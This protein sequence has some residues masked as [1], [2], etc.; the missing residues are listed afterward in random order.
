MKGKT[1][2]VVAVFSI[3]FGIAW[4]SAEEPAGDPVFFI[5][6]IGSHGLYPELDYRRFT[7]VLTA[8]GRSAFIQDIRLDQDFSW[9]TA[10]RLDDSSGAIGGIRRDQNFSLI[11]NADLLWLTPLGSA[12]L[13]AGIGADFD[14]RQSIVEMNDYNAFT[15]HEKEET[16]TAPYALRSMLLWASRGDTLAQGYRLKY[17]LGVSPAV[18]TWLTDG[19][20]D[21]VLEYVNDTL[22]DADQY[23]H[24]A[25]ISG[26]WNRQLGNLLVTG[27]LSYTFGY[28]SRSNKYLS[29]DTT[30]DGYRETV[31]SYQDWSARSGTG[32]P[33]EE[34]TSFNQNDEEY[35][36]RIDLNTLIRITLSDSLHLQLS[37]SY[38]PLDISSRISYTRIE[39]DSIPD[40]MSWEGVNRSQ[41]WGNFMI[42]G[43]LASQVDSEKEGMRL[44]LYYNRT[45]KTVLLDGAQAAGQRL[46]HRDNPGRY[47]EVDLGRDPVRG[48]IMSAVDYPSLTVVHDLQL[49]SGRF[50]QFDNQIRI[51]TG[52][53]LNGVL[54]QEHYRAYNLN[55]RT[56]WEEVAAS[57]GLG[58]LLLPQVGVS[59][60]LGERW[61]WI[62]DIGAFRIPGDYTQTHNTAPQDLSVGRVTEDGTLDLLQRGGIAFALRMRFVLLP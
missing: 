10:Q 38:T 24:Q 3:L 5:S 56:V 57:N 8:V 45:A 40:D 14:W 36:H 7:S 20:Q 11:A 9:E 54:H 23:A 52:L 12:V 50:W 16:S 15:Q 60:P 28:T 19:T 49:L 53:E 4:V 27:G 58:W 61:R 35:S 2:L 44:G 42:G 6:G 62:G 51:F 59:V 47:T 33:E 34:I 17:S 30:G 22:N 43:S 18:F 26:D 46:F 13:G 29:I 21:P 31:L 1:C 55:T 37:A 41:D 39:T 32:G 48:S 25:G